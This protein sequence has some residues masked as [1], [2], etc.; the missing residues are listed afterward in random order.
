[1]ECIE[2]YVFFKNLQNYFLGKKE[3]VEMVDRNK[4][5]LLEECFCG[6]FVIVLEIEGVFWLKDDGK[7][8]W[9]KCYFLL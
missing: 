7:K 1:M 5:V 6:S 3:I 8:F 4:E 9:K 2:K